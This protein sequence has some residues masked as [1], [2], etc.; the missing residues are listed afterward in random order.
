M[1]LM[2][3]HQEFRDLDFEKAK[4]LMKIPIIVDARRIYD[5]EKL[6]EMGFYYSGVGA[7]NNSH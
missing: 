1:V 4:K 5:P 2:T 3:A 7:V 6:K